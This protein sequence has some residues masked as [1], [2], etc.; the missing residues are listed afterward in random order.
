MKSIANLPNLINELP[1]AE[2]ALFNRIFDCSVEKG[3][4]FLPESL[5]DWA[6]K[7]IGHCEE[8]RIVRVTNK[9][10]LE[11][12]LFNEL[13]SKRPIDVK[14]GEELERI[15]EGAKGPFCDPKNR[16][17]ADVFGRVSGKYCITA[18]NIA[19]YDYLHAVLIFSDHNPF[20]YE[21]EKIKDYIE[22]AF[23]WYKKARKYD[24]KAIFPFFM[25]N[26]LWKAS[27]SMVHGHAQILL[28]KQPY[29]KAE[30]IRRV[31]EDYAKA[32]A[33]NYFDDLF[34][35]HESLGLGLKVDEVKVTANLTPVKE[36]EIFMISKSIKALPFCI[37]MALRCYYRLGV[38]SFTLAILMPPLIATDG[39]SNF[40]YIV[41]LVDRGD[42]MSRTTDIGAM[43]LYAG[44]SVVESDPFKLIEE[45]GLEVRSPAKKV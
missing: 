30:Y 5:K 18:G 37:S 13:R 12:A 21:E 44:H 6:A 20:V 3:E 28:A 10:T 26:C 9:I 15:I 33:S 32:Y 36:K 38:R 43:E 27:A 45:L 7:K 41:R 25:W 1:K 4:I 31:A 22:T 16:T 2:K 11:G 35:V 8:Q 19:K 14:V 39:W 23:R 42:P 40:P 24:E 17:P 29:A 34:I